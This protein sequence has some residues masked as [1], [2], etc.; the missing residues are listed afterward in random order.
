M[1]T[2]RKK[3]QA[4]SE[5]PKRAKPRKRKAAKRKAAKKRRSS[6]ARSTGSKRTRRPLQL[7][8]SIAD[9]AINS[10]ALAPL[11]DAQRVDLAAM[12]S[13]K[14]LSTR[15]AWATDETLWRKAVRVVSPHWKRLRHPWPVVAWAYL[16]MDGA[17]GH[18]R[19]L[20]STR[21]DDAPRG[22]RRAAARAPRSTTTRSQYGDDDL[23]DA[24]PVRVERLRVDATGIDESGEYRGQ[25][26]WWR[27][28]NASIDSVVRAATATAARAIVTGR[29]H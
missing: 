19:G 21:D 2:K 15:P 14:T 18:A 26:I 17:V 22:K 5:A 4:E 27:V 20:D 10:P 13:R 1:A 12:D 28:W 8:L 7:V 6:A 23:D 16:R 9:I 25:G 24:Q 11:S 3:Q 29:A